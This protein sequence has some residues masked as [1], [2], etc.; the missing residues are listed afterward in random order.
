MKSININGTNYPF[1][2]SFRVIKN[3]EIRTGKNFAQLDDL[4]MKDLLILITECFKSGEM[5][6]TGKTSIND[7]MVEQWLD[8]DISILKQCQAEIEKQSSAL[9][10][11][12][13]EPANGESSENEKKPVNDQG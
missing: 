12:W 13:N 2:M 6:V 8:D 7:D 11:S 1:R 9:F 5:K 10:G 4:G 3:V